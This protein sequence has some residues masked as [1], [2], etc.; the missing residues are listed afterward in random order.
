LTKKAANA[1]AFCLLIYQY[2]LVLKIFYF[3]CCNGQHTYSQW[4][5][6]NGT[7]RVALVLVLKSPSTL[8]MTQSN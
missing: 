1:N 7:S 2:T 5:G 4:P 6:L 8:S 3:N